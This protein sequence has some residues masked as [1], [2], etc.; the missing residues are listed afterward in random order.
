MLTLGFRP[1]PGKALEKTII[2]DGVVDG[3]EDGGTVEVA[4]GYDESCD[5]VEGGS[6]C[7][8]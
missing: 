6:G 7:E 4:G 1:G 5:G 2:I 3:G 8:R